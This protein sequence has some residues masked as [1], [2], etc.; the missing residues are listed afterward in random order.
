M[1]ISIVGYGKMGQMVA[2]A[3]E[4]RKVAVASI[5]DPFH[6]EA[7]HQEFSAESME[8]V[9][10]CI[11]FTQPDVAMQNI[12]DACRFKVPLVMATTGWTDKMEEVRGMVEEAGIGMVYSS[13]F[14][15]GVNIFFKIIEE[16]ASI[17]NHFDIYDL[18]GY[19]LHHSRKKDSPS[20]TAKT[21]ANLIL[22]KVDRKTKIVEDKLD[23]APEDHEFHFASVRGGDIPGTH[24]IQFE[25]SFDSIELKHTARNRMGFA[26]GSIFAA[27][28]ILEKKG[29]F[30]EKDMMEK[31]LNSSA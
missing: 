24:V 3:A 20:G 2:Q 8:G 12:T 16:A 10:A 22:E 19:E 29:L 30:T 23:R 7:T 25:S 5:I 18:L 26:S 28:W 11:C 1:K 15:L 4:E 31:L 14:S 9:D 21:L 17:I 27:E 6:P 13:N